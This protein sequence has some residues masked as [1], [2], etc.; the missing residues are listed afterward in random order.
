MSSQSYYVA[1]VEPNNSVVIKQN[2]KKNRKFLQNIVTKDSKIYRVRG[3]T[4][5]DAIN[6]LSSHLGVDL[7]QTVLPRE[8]KYN[9]FEE[10]SLEE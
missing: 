8:S 6:V 3:H 1:V 10:I 2:T 7:I 5:R 9:E 4:V